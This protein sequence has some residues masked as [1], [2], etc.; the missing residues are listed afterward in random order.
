MFQT[1]NQN[2]WG[3]LKTV[4]PKNRLLIL[5]NPMKIDDLGVPLF[6]WKPP[7]GSV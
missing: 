6:F 2:I 4:V 5:E 7:Y 1:T 3:V